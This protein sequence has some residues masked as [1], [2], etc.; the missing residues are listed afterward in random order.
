M[1]E[2]KKQKWSELKHAYGSAE[3]IPELI[4]T[5]SDT[6]KHD[7]YC[8]E[9]YFTLWSAL[10]H[11]GDVY[12]ASYAAFP[13]FIEECEKK[14]SETQW[15]VM[16]LAVNI[17]IGRLTN[18]RAPSIPNFLKASYFQ[19]KQKMTL[20]CTQIMQQ[21]PSEEAAIL[22]MMSVALEVDDGDWA[23]SIQEFNPR[24]AKKFLERFWEGEFNA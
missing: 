2:L 8:D 18:R 12:T 10:C 9:P 11:Q 16:Q 17:E 21:N 15:S 14:P 3:N 1:L 5:L 20:A 24:V 4:N 13:Y 6:P 19:A 7:S 23:Q 22:T